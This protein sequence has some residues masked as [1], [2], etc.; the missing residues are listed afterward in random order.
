MALYATGSTGTIGRHFPRGIIPIKQRLES[1][2]GSFLQLKFEPSDIVIHAGARVG[3]N[4]VAHSLEDSFQINVAGSRNLALAALQSN[5]SKFVYIS[6]CHV[7]KFGKEFLSENDQIN[8]INFYAEQKYLGEQEV[9]KVFQDYPDKV[10]IIRVFSLLGWEM[11]HNTLGGA[12]NRIL[13]GELNFQT[14]NG[15]DIRDFLTPKQVAHAIKAVAENPL[16]LG[17]VNLCSG[18]G[19]RV[20]EAARSL[21]TRDRRFDVNMLENIK[22]GVSESPRIVGNN[23]KMKGLAPEVNLEWTFMPHNH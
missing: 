11:P 13:Q 4:K 23:A 14:M 15:D 5:I 9:L 20:S 16:A 21:L 3:P 12:V 10:C 1:D 18:V 6:T 8:P 17:I 2:L 19:L 7:Y 22:G